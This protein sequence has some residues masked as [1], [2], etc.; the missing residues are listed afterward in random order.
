[1]RL[2]VKGILYSFNVLRNRC[3]LAFIL[4]FFVPNPLN[5]TETRCNRA[6][7]F[8][9]NSIAESI[10]ASV[11]SDKSTGTIILFISETTL[12]LIVI[13]GHFDLVI[14]RVTV[15]PIILLSFSSL[16]LSY[17]KIKLALTDS[18]YDKIC[19]CLFPKSIRLWPS[20]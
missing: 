1:M 3:A 6:F 4:K 12:F 17:N 5:S 11:L 7:V 16:C 19:S 10:C 20:L 2:I 13:T 8:L 18:E 9:L 15:E 14:I